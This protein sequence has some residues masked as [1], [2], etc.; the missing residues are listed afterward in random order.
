MAVRVGVRLP[1]VAGAMGADREYH[2]TPRA[3]TGPSP[4]QREG[5]VTS[6]SPRARL[7]QL[8]TSG[9]ASGRA[10]VAR[11]VSVAQVPIATA[12]RAD[13]FESDVPVLG[14]PVAI[15]F[16][17]SDQEVLGYQL[18]VRSHSHRLAAIADG[19]LRD[20]SRVLESLVA[21]SPELPW[22]RP[23]DRI[24]QLAMIEVVASYIRDRDHQKATSWLSRVISQNTPEN[25]AP[26]RKVRCAL[27]ALLMT[28]VG[29]VR[30]ALLALVPIPTRRDWIARVEFNRAVEFIAQKLID[31]GSQRENFGRCTTQV[32]LKSLCSGLYELLGSMQA[33]KGLMSEAK[34]RK[35]E[36]SQ[37]GHISPH[38]EDGIKLQ[39]S[40]VQAYIKFQELDKARSEFR[41]ISGLEI[42]VDLEQRF[43]RIE[44][45]LA[46]LS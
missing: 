5:G 41:Q 21:E 4:R 18:M 39:M 32:R 24:R 6:L 28:N 17:V 25:L 45:E 9:R 1:P 43:D 29:Y 22:I 12:R 14:V 23:Y 13:S 37:L 34:M 38:R 36:I 11:V 27:S 19:S 26:L 44:E 8:V 3:P 20:S 31:R 35:H 40:I 15:A 10:V 16:P 30:A 42:P 2:Q 7:P 33:S 46:D